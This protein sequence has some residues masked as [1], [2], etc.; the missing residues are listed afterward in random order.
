[1]FNTVLKDQ[2]KDLGYRQLCEH[3]NKHGHRS[4][5]MAEA[6]RRSILKEQERKPDKKDLGVL[7]TYEC[8]YCGLWFVGHD[9]LKSDN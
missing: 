3:Y 7:C 4:Q 9:R 5:G 8:R 2:L 1:M 6:Q